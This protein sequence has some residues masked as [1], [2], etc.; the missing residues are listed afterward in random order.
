MK[1]PRMSSTLSI[2]QSRSRS[3]FDF[4]IF[5]HL[6]QYK[7]SSAISQL[8]NKLGSYPLSMSDISVQYL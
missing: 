7:L 8:L 6:P 2:L 3:R 5:S 4:E 1:S